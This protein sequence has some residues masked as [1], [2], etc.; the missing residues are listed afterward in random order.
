NA[1]Y[2]FEAIAEFTAVAQRLS[3][4]AAARDLGI[5]A[6]ALSR[7]IAAL[8]ARLGV[9]LLQRT[10]RRVALTE[11]G[12]EFLA[13]MQDLLG[14]MDEAEAA[15]SRHAAEPTGLPRVA[16]HNLFGQRHI[17]PLIR[18][19][20]ARHPKLR[21]ELTFSDRFE[22]LLDARLDC[23]VRIGA[24][25]RGGDLIARVLAPNRRLLVASPSY[26]KSAGT[27]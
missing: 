18:A 19:F 3:F 8:E 23:A 14:R 25:E 9:R 20:A 1:R 4:T 27:P 13:R 26:L 6:S 7:R 22:D 24:L 15:V 5:D 17:A 11:A 21:V 2:R 10:T 16:V 12:A